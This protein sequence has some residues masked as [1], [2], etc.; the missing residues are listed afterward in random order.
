MICYTRD[1]SGDDK[2]CGYVPLECYISLKAHSL[3]VLLS[4]LLIK[5]MISLLYVSDL[6]PHTD[7]LSAP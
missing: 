4:K 6:S 7:L 5:L 2:D 1:L 3:V